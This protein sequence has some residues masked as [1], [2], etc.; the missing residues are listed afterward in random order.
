M[1]Y[2]NRLETLFQLGQITAGE[3]ECALFFQQIYDDAINPIEHIRRDA[4]VVLGVFREDIGAQ[5]YNNLVASI[6]LRCSYSAIGRVIHKSHH[7]ARKRFIRSLQRFA[8]NLEVPC[9]VDSSSSNAM[10]Y[11]NHGEEKHN[12]S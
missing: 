2:N 8:K 3:Y 10:N 4:L 9:H 7:T 6:G 12:A 11:I 5:D 1:N